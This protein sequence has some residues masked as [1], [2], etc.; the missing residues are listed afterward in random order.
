MKGIYDISVDVETIG[1]GS[2]PAL[3]SIGAVRFKKEGHLAPMPNAE[4]MKRSFV[5]YLEDAFYA[6]I[7][8][9][10][11]AK[12]YGGT[13]DTNTLN[14]W[15]SPELEVARRC[16]FPRTDTGKPVTRAPLKEVLIA[17]Y[18]WCDAVSVIEAEDYAEYSINERTVWS[19]GAAFDVSILNTYY[20]RC[21]MLPQRPWR[22]NKSRDTRTIWEVAV[23]NGWERPPEPTGMIAHHPTWDAWAQARD[24]IKANQYVH[25]LCDLSHKHRIIN[26]Q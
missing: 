20:E 9:E 19:N 15:M 5:V 18:K 17:F 4:L 14:W 16:A 6:L 8:P 7:D 23:E 10:D 13:F 12:K 11:C 3:L 25:N 26:A 21:D 2:C 22:Y 1:T 24:V